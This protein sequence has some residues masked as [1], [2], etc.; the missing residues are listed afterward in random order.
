MFL[1][2]HIAD[3][4][5]SGLLQLKFVTH[6]IKHNIRSR[7]EKRHLSI[8]SVLASN[9]IGVPIT[10]SHFLAGQQKQ[11]YHRSAN[12]VNQAILYNDRLQDQPALISSNKIINFITRNFN[13][14]TN[15][16]NKSTS[17]IMNEKPFL[18]KK[19]LILRKFS[20]LEFEKLCH[21]NLTEEQLAKDVSLSAAYLLLFYLCNDLTENVFPI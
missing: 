6:N 19:A 2:S 18:P 16:R 12:T 1:L 15:T 7:C 21:A 10:S 4:K 20:R 8:D 5:I 14:N 13:T 9:F 3:N 11:Y 17:S